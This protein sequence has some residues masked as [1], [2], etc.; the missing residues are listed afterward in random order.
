MRYRVPSRILTLILLVMLIVVGFFSYTQS[1]WFP[2]QL[3]LGLLKFT[4][5]LP[6]QQPWIF[7]DDNSPLSSEIPPD[8]HRYFSGSSSPAGADDEKKEAVV[9][10]FKY[11]WNAYVRDAFGY[12]E[13]FPISRRGQNLSTGGGIGYTI[14]DAIDTMYLMGLES[15]YEVARGWIETELSFN[16]SHSAYST[17]E[18]T[19]RVLGGLLSAHYLTSDPLYLHHASDLGQRLAGAFNT[20]SGLPGSTISLG[21]PEPRNSYATSPAEAGSI[22]LEFKYLAELTGN[23]TFWVKAERAMEVFREAKGDLG[24]DLKG[25]VP[26]RIRIDTGTFQSSTVRLGSL[27]DSYYEYLL[28]QYLQTNMKE[29]VYQNMYNDA[30]DGIADNLL[31]RTPLENLTYMAELNPQGGRAAHLSTL[32]WNLGYR[33]EHLVCFLAGTLMLGAVTS[34][35][36]NGHHKVSVPPRPREFTSRGLRDWKMGI[37]LLE[38][39]MTTHDTLT[40]L[41]PEVAQFRSEDDES[42]SYKKDWFIPGRFIK[43]NRSPYEA[44]Y[45]LRSVLPQFI[46]ILSPPLIRLYRPE[47]VESIFIA[48]RLTGDPRYRE[49]AWNIFS[50]IEKHARLPSGGYATLM[51]VDQIPVKW[52]DKQETFFLSETLKYLYL[53]F[54]DS[55]VLPIRDIVFNTEVGTFISHRHCDILSTDWDLFKAHPLPLFNP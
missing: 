30:V 14:V 12:D 23:R 10:A 49:W 29:P 24:K 5:S 4:T 40:G 25:L 6:P 15:E 1:I 26:T 28:K 47:I 27:A 44:R 11:A 34:G 53:T 8:D 2:E 39:C 38:G 31:R 35:A 3:K 41:A 33:Q 46:N 51:D 52:V 16:H 48:H 36:R 50:S 43:G 19:I 18:T 20:S 32:E 7:D 37:D 17:F 55:S 42:Y 22:Q 45:M 54:C 13:Y 9:K 21:A